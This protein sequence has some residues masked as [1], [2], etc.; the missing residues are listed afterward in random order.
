MKKRVFVVIATLFHLFS[1]SQNLKLAGNDTICLNAP[2]YFE[3]QGK[4]KFEAIIWKTNSGSIESKQKNGVWVL[5]HENKEEYNLE[6][7]VTTKK[8][9]RTVILQK[10]LTPLF[11]KTT[12]LGNQKPIVNNVYT[13]ECDY[14]K[15]DDYSWE[16]YPSFTGTIVQKEGK[17]ATILWHPSLSKKANLRLRIRKCNKIYFKEF[18]ITFLDT[19]EI[20]INSNSAIKSGNTVD[21]LVSSTIPFSY[22]SATIDF[23]DGSIE[24]IAAGTI[25]ETQTFKHC[26]HCE[27]GA[28]NRNVIITY[29]NANHSGNDV[30]AIMPIK[31]EKGECLLTTTN[32]ILFKYSINYN[33]V[34]GLYEVTFFNHSTIDRQ[35]KTIGGIELVY[36]NSNQLIP[37]TPE[38]TLFFDPGE[39]TFEIG[40]K[41][42]FTVKRQQ[43]ILNLPEITTPSFTPDFVEIAEGNP[44]LFSP[45]TN[46][47]TLTYYW[48]FGDGSYSNL[49]ET[50]KSFSA[51]KQAISF[52]NVSLTVTNKYGYAKSFSYAQNEV[53]IYNLQLNGQL[54]LEDDGTL[55]F[56]STDALPENSLFLWFLN[57]KQIAQTKYPYYKPDKEGSYWLKIMTD[58]GNYITIPDGVTYLKK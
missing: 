53:K 19:P 29:H 58:N 24:N 49:R 13:Y 42:L 45:K 27:H 10:K 11:P 39:Y 22:D 55:L 12:M 1:F 48:E 33:L 51:D 14:A 8:N 15:G 40:L 44:V 35:V 47:N 32:S 26:Y 16:I 46:D 23:G 57:D 31:I 50:V 28:G 52:K 18:P 9:K 43:I 3:I 20:Q 38:F 7:V 36:P 25:A 37:Y 6:A 5:F 56:T 21:F 34:K 30:T 2:E 54:T 17:K 41:E 4:T